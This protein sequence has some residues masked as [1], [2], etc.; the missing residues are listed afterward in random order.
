MPKFV[1]T[2]KTIRLEPSVKYPPNLEKLR[3]IW[4]SDAAIRKEYRRLQAAADK[5]MKRFIQAGFGK[6][7]YVRELKS[8]KRVSQLGSMQE[9]ARQL[10]KA[11]Q[12]LRDK[13]YTLSGIRK[14]Q[15]QGLQKMIEKGM[16]KPES[17]TGKKPTRAELDALFEAARRRGFLQQY[18]SDE[19][20]DIYRT[21][22]EQGRETDYTRQ[23]WQGP[24]SAMQ[25]KLDAANV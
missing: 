19:V 11:S 15:E 1:P 6:T 4:G 24:L 20:L 12:K 7:P 9:V 21:R 14:S 18:G 13:R 23:Q 16:I 25:R 2:P 10:A 17:A 3:I 8:I 5:R 22:Q